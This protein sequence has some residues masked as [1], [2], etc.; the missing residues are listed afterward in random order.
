MPGEVWVTPI[1]QATEAHIPVLTANVTSPGSTVGTV[2]SANG[3][4]F[5]SYTY[6]AIPTGIP[7]PSTLALV[8]GVLVLA[9][10]RKF[11]G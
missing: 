3:S 4:V 5:V 9:G 10:I 1:R 8:G 7:E 11:R 6:E 2:G